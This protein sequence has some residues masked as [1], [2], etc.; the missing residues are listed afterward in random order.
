[1]PARGGFSRPA[2]KPRRIAMEAEPPF[3]F[4]FVAAPSDLAPYLNSL[5]I[6]RIGSRGINEMLPA[7]SGQLLLAASG[8]GGID[9]GNGLIEAPP[10]AFLI[11]PLSSARPFAIAGPAIMIGASF[12][13]H[14]WAALTGLP[15]A[16]NADRFL[17]ATHVLGEAG[18]SAAV[19]IAR[20]LR[21]DSIGLADALDELAGI[22]RDRVRPLPPS[23]AEVISS[24]YAWLSGSLNP[25]P[26]DLYRSLPMSERQI[27]R[28]VKRFFG[29]APSRLRR[30]YRAIR[31]ATLLAD[32][33]LPENRRAEVLQS[34]YD[35][36]HLIREIREF[37]GR[38]PSLLTRTEPTVSVETL[39][40]PGYGVVKLFAG[41][42]T[43]Q[44][45]QG[46]D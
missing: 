12:N 28:L 24:T 37:T 44:L 32:P 20:K 41:E 43:E 8:S 4:E 35:Q 40:A 13:Y 17:T 19:E 18:G 39:G 26:D 11:G 23:H 3:A 46:R 1:M 36:A 16:Q 29:L 45:D 38:T 25:K 22:L 9:F 10:D 15:V 42:E 34:F 30:R 33:D 7:Y 14:G 6:L 27:Q 2:R 31:A 5:Y 21:K